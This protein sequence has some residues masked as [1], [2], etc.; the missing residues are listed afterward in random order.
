VDFVLISGDLQRANINAPTFTQAH[1]VLSLKEAD[2][3]VWP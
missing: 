3:P 2:I 1:A